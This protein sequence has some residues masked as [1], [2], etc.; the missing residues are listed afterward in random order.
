MQGISILTLRHPPSGRVISRLCSGFSRQATAFY[1]YTIAAMRTGYRFIVRLIVASFAFCL[2]LAGCNRQS[3]LPDEIGFNKHVRPILSD[4]CFKCHGPDGNTRE[5]D[6]RLDLEEDAKAA[7]D[8]Y[9]II[10]PGSA[11]QSELIRRI[12]LP[13]DHDEYM[14]HADANKT[15]TAREKALLARWIDEGAA[16]EPHWAYISPTRPPVPDTRAVRDYAHPIDRFITQ[17]LDEMGR[18]Y[19]AP[20]D[21]VTLLRRVYADVIGLPPTYA[22]VQAFLDDKRPD[23]FERVVDELLESPHFGER[24][25]ISWLDIVRY[26]DTNGFHSDVHRNI[27]PYRDYVIQS[28]NANKPFDQFTLEQLAGDLL[29]NPTLEHRI[30]SGFNR[31]NQITKEGG[32]Q[33]KEYRIKYAADRVRAVSATW[34]GATVGCAECHDHKFDPYTAQDFYSL[35][36]YF[37]DIQEKG[38]YRNSPYVPPEMPVPPP[39]L[40]D[41]VAAFDSLLVGL[42]RQLQDSSRLN[43][44]EI[45]QIRQQLDVNGALRDTL[46]KDMPATLVTVPVPPREVRVLARGN[47]M[48]TTGTVVEP[49]TPTFLPA[50]LPTSDQRRTR[51]DLANWLV[52]P[53]NPLTARVFVNRLWKQFFNRGISHVLDDFGSQGEPPT[54]PELLDWLAVEFVEH[55]WDIKHMVRT[56]VTSRAYQQSSL[57]PDEVWDPENK[58]IARQA[59]F[60]LDAELVRDNA[61]AVSGLLNRAVG[62]RSIQPYQPEGYWAN[63]NTFGVQGPGT[64]WQ[65]EQ[66][67][68]Q[69]RRGVYMYWKRTF[70]HPGMLAFDA[71]TRQESEAQRAS[72]NT[73]AQALVLLNDPTYVEAARVFAAR[74]LEEGGASL[75][76]QIV[77][78]YREA[79]SRA[80]RIEE[81]AL[82]RDLHTTQLAMYEADEAGAMQ[83]IKTG[84]A[85]TDSK[86]YTASPAQLAAATAVTRAIF[87]L[88]EMITR[89]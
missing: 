22:Q 25:A 58:W 17:A 30:A 68:E 34:M 54:H 3:G 55:G 10:R 88:H 79:L 47:W 59:R 7:R 70:L 6:L 60:R 89:Y 40:A 65:A 15:L 71:P 81:L 62:G 64:T 8:G 78:A 56:I 74:M 86:L 18:A 37:A 4:N 63:I 69:Y 53:D 31:L 16:W 57:L 67:A 42:H 11:K 9:Q 83:L 84:V 26:A 76:E 2:L 20:A 23:A 35:S 85:P 52:H 72:S 82:L 75:D 28:F 48:D 29:P 21:S 32:A 73:P 43:S 14:P 38:I 45:A 5:G 41:S 24:L 12:N 77:W 87:N 46:V 19:A 51:V 61:L 44:A 1:A 36:A 33:D 27:Y 49:A 50:L 80:P 13:A 66:D 39:A